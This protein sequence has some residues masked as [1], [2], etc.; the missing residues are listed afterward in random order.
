MVCIAFTSISTSSTDGQRSGRARD[1]SDVD[2][3]TTST[4][5]SSE[6]DDISFVRGVGIMVADSAGEGMA[7]AA[8]GE[9]AVEVAFG[10]V[11]DVVKDAAG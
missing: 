6:S 10:L 8:N 3:T 9:D 2:A 11:D 1:L 5:S 7:E 4:S